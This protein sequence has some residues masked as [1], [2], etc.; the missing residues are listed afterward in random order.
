MTPAA[1][2]ELPPALPSRPPI[3]P[4]VFGV[5]AMPTPPLPHDPGA[6]P[7]AVA[8]ATPAAAALLPGAVAVPPLPPRAAVPSL[9][10]FAVAAFALAPAEA[11]SAPS[12]PLPPVA[13]QGAGAVVS[14]PL[15]PAEL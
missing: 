8:V 11:P 2:V 13:V 3:V 9:K 1:A 10:A 15:V 5:A 6:R 4:V 14:V 12:S 7:V